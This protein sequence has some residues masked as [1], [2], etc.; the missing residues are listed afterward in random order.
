ML[1]GV[2]VHSSYVY[3][4]STNWTIHDAQV[5]PFFDVIIGFLSMFRMPAFFLISG[6]FCHMTLTRYGVLRFLKVRLKRI[7]VPL[8]TTAIIVNGIQ[9]YILERYHDG[10]RDA[11]ELLLSASYWLGGKWVSHLWFLNDLLVFFL[12]VAIVYALLNRPHGWLGLRSLKWLA[13]SGL[14]VL[15][16]PAIL[17]VADFIGN[18][19]PLVI[20][21]AAPFLDFSELTHYGVFF[22]FGFLMGA[23]PKLM[24][25]FPNPRIW[26]LML[27]CFFILLKLVF[28]ADQYHGIGA[29]MVF[30]YFDAYISWHLCIICFYLFRKYFNSASKQF[31][32]L[33]DASYSIYLFHHIL[34]VVIGIALIP[35]TFNIY[36]KFFTLMLTAGAI[37]LAI[38]HFGV[39]RSP[40]LRLLFNGKTPMESDKSIKAYS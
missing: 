26:A 6:F 12:V 31:A 28:E 20:T 39:L 27:M 24:D 23:Y 7:A 37:S 8:I 10:H 33:S 30:H 22:T 19:F 17:L 40:V 1:L 13:T 5:S 25:D 3:N 36:L 2:V 38:H 35:L 34:V 32:Y 18:R 29:K 9:N 11:I 4:T 21:E 15:L 14:Y 16:L